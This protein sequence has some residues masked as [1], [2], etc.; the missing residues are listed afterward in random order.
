MFVDLC[1]YYRRFVRNFALVAASLHA[2]T[3]KA[4]VFLI[5]RVNVRRLFRSLKQALTSPVIVAYPV[6]MAEVGT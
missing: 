6:F 2:L 3:Q 4:A 5:G 1:S